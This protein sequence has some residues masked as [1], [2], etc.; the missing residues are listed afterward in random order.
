MADCYSVVDILR[1]SSI[2]SALHYLFQSKH[3]R[4]ICSSLRSVR[5]L[6]Y[7]DIIVF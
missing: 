2:F 7:V 4:Y 3:G 5:V 1:V 6:S